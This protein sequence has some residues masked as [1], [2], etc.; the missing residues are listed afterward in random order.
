MNMEPKLGEEGMC[1]VCPAWGAS[2]V[3]LGCPDG[4]VCVCILAG[5]GSMQKTV[6]H[7]GSKPDSVSPPLLQCEGTIVGMAFVQQEDVPEEELD[8]WY[9]HVQQHTAFAF[10]IWVQ[11]RDLGILLL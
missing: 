5:V 11:I 6:A 7:F 3:G 2:R 1:G 4:A 10:V 9:E 8:V